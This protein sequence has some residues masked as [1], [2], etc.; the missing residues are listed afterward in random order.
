[1]QRRSYLLRTT[2]YPNIYVAQIL[3]FVE[4][5]IAKIHISKI[6]VSAKLCALKLSAKPLAS[7]LH[8]S[9][10]LHVIF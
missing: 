2:F 3:F 5:D 4:E 6:V 7:F 8:T 1:M 10:K 9:L